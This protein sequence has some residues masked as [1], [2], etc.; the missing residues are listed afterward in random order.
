MLYIVQIEGWKTIYARVGMCASI[1]KR[2]GRKLGGLIARSSRSHTNVHL[3]LPLP[4]HSI[5]LIR[6]VQ[7]HSTYAAKNVF[8]PCNDGWGVMLI[9]RPVLPLREMRWMY[10]K[11]M[12]CL[13]FHL[14]G[15]RTLPDINYSEIPSWMFNK[16]KMVLSIHFTLWISF[17]HKKRGGE[18]ITFFA[19][20]FLQLP[21]HCEKAFSWVFYFYRIF[22]FFYNLHFRD[23]YTRE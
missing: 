4:H 6:G 23:M 8:S 21:P 7:L 10:G 13:S 16:S 11:I 17:F 12:K 14:Y 1:D 18:M 5:D 19:I 3:A 15:R 2:K 9:E 20:D 22:F